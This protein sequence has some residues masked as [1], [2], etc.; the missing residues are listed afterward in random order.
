MGP[1]QLAGGFVIG[2]LATG[3][4]CAL[5]LYPGFLAYLGARPAAGSHAW[6]G[7]AVLAG[8]LSAML[9]LG[10]LIAALQVAVGRVLAVVTP[11]ADAAVI[12]LGIA[13]LLGADPFSRLPMLAMGPGDRSR[14]ALSAFWYGAL[15]GP[16]T[17]PC[18][19]PLLVAIFTLSTGVGS[20]A[21]KLAFF[22]AF[23]LG[24]GAPLLAI[25]LLAASWR[26]ALL[27]ALARR[28]ALLGRVAGAVL[29]LVGAVDL[30]T[31]A[32]FALLYLGL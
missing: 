26:S 24:F 25:S 22:L 12:A 7:L 14:P 28:Y 32:P 21:E 23:G 13:L 17:L 5:P 11:L 6:L 31:N 8:V 30:W 4:P 9:A 15:Y 19:G 29:V 3:S 18:S 1:E 20:F 16:M 2:L 27:R 10:A